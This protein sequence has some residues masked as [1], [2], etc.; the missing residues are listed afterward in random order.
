LIKWL[1]LKGTRKCEVCH[2]QYNFQEEYGTY[3]EVAQKTKNFLFADKHR[4]FQTIAYGFYI[5][6]LGRRA[7][8]QLSNCYLFFR[9]I[10]K[11]I[12]R[13]LFKAKSKAAAQPLI[14]RLFLSILALFKSIF[15]VA[16]NV[17]ISYHLAIIGVA[18]I[19][20]IK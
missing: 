15:K 20:R 18:E 2:T 3:Y 1:K 7:K 13:V 11:S 19:K 6:L 4:I 12:L 14:R 9:R 8:I 10:G 16:Y 17:F 5:Y